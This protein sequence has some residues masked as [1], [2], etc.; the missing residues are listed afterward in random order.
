MNPYGNFSNNNMY[1]GYS[2]NGQTTSN[3]LSAVVQRVSP[4]VIQQL[5]NN[6]VA[7]PQS[8][9]ALFQH[10]VQPATIDEMINIMK[11]NGATDF[12][13]ADV[14]FAMWRQ[15][16][17]HNQRVQQPR[18]AISPYDVSGGNV[19]GSTLYGNRPASQ[20]QSYSSRTMNTR[21]QAVPQNKANPYRK[22]EVV[23][24]KKPVELR[25]VPTSITSAP[26][27]YDS[28]S[29]DN[30]T[31]LYE[32][33]V[34]KDKDVL[35]NLTELTRVAHKY[36]VKSS[37]KHGAR[38]YNISKEDVVGIQDIIKQLDDRS[39][40]FTDLVEFLKEK[41][42]FNVVCV[43]ESILEGLNILINE[44]AMVEY[45][46]TNPIFDSVDEAS[47]MLT[48]MSIDTGDAD[49]NKMVTVI[50]SNPEAKE[51][52]QQCCNA[53][54]RRIGDLSDIRQCKDA[55]VS[56]K[57]HFPYIYSN[58]DSRDISKHLKEVGNTTWVKPGGVLHAYLIDSVDMFMEFEL[59]L[60]KSNL[61]FYNLKG[62]V[63]PKG[64][65]LTRV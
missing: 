49:L 17:L 2:V 47:D 1:G 46:E 39:N 64:I 9:N 29:S 43:K 50:Q 44:G 7:Q 31:G 21:Q 42:K 33:V 8:Q 27:D 4:E 6:G 40:L 10:F 20:N 14:K 32:F 35:P 55:S 5:I 48:G 13:E 24:E 60:N 19:A 28:V 57:R 51:V 41:Q 52:F 58:V 61:L 15:V 22:E 37:T 36:V 30:A 63:L 62:I 12:T 11:S 59:H 54:V 16:E 34:S 18:G 26:F 53:S 45:W 3:G 25:L 65:K 56:A 38:F 23:T